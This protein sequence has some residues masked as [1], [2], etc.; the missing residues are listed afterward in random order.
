MVTRKLLVS[1]LLPH[2]S[3]HHT[4][5]H[6]TDTPSLLSKP[7]HTYRYRASHSMKNHP[8]LNRPNQRGSKM[9]MFTSNQPAS[10]PTTR[11]G[12]ASAKIAQ[13]GAV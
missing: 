7:Q 8:A 5:S 9:F 2:C 11:A 6:H 13:D 10:Q 4:T 3:P 1:P 12:L